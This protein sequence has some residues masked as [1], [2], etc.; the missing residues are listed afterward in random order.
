MKKNLIVAVLFLTIFFSSHSLTYAANSDITWGDVGNFFISLFKIYIAP[1]VNIDSSN[2]IN[3]D[4]GSVN[5]KGIAKR[6]IPAA[7]DENMKIKYV[8]AFINDDYQN[9]PTLTT[10]ENI[11]ITLSHLIHYKI[12]NSSFPISSELKNKFLSDSNHPAPS[13]MASSAC[14]DNAWSKFN[15]VPIQNLQITDNKSFQGNQVIKEIIPKNS[16]Q[17][18]ITS[19]SPPIDIQHDTGIHTDIMHQNFIPQSLMPATAAERQ[20]LFTQLM[21]PASQQKK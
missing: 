19:N 21:W 2:K 6:A 4:Y 14:L 13:P 5:Q 8:E 16:Q 17:S 10:C 3:T 7:M 1:V 11:P 18:E 12:S 20:T 15:N 9:D